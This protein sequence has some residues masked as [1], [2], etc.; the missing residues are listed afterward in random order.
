VADQ[1][2][3]GARAIALSLAQREAGASLGFSV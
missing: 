2:Q 1:H 3:L